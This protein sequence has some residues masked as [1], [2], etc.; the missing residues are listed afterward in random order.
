MAKEKDTGTVKALVLVDTYAWREPIENTIPTQFRRVEVEP[1]AGTTS[2]K[3]KEIEVTAEEFDRGSSMTPPALAKVGS[4]EAKRFLG[5]DTLPDGKLTELSDDELATLVAAR[6]GNPEGM[7][8]DEL[9]GFVV[10]TPGNP[11]SN[12]AKT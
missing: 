9:V 5:R 6:G 4:K 8:R 2:A 7:N 1:D 3:G 11:S 10:G 12:P